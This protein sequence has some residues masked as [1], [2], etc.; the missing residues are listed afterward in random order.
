MRGAFV[1]ALRTPPRTTDRTALR[2]LG[3]RD[4]IL[5]PAKALT[6]TE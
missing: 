1:E 4:V 5:K 3:G 2:T 6:G